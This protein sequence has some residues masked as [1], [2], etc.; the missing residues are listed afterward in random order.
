MK[1]TL[2][3]IP[4]LL[5]S[6]AC[7]AQ[8]CTGSPPINCSNEKVITPAIQPPAGL[9]VVSATC[10][11]LVIKWTGAANQEH[12]AHAIHHNPLTNA[13]DSIVVSNITCDANNNWTA[14]IPVVAN[15]KY[16]L[17]VEA[18]G[19]INGCAF[20][21]YST[22]RMLDHAVAACNQK[23]NML[24]FSGKVMLQGAYNLSTGK[25]NNTLNETGLLQAH[26]A[27]QPYASAGFN[28]AGTENVGAAFFAAHPTIVDWVLLEIRDP[29]APLSIVGRRAVFVTQDGTLVD[30][31]GISTAIAFSGIAPGKYNVSLRHRN[32]LAI[33]S[34]AAVDFLNGTGSYDFTTANYNTYKNQNY[35]STTQ[36]GNVWAM[37]GGNVLHSGVIRYS[38][39]GNIPSYILSVTLGGLLST[40]INNVY[41]TE[42]INMNGNIRYTGPGNDQ[43][44]LLNTVLG[45]SMNTILKEQL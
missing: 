4:L 11:T 15:T 5:F 17:T 20:Y 14:T 41:A 35:T 43:S 27:N 19:M 28:Y 32:H 36:M 37:R 12:L 2:I 33:R 8:S 42:D 38:G 34:S 21:S 10:S 25:M 23:G 24:T 18:K 16:S 29:N 30:T 6:S 39:P 3:I 9:Q 26:A 31:D 7:I 44:A 40:I 45:G 13:M 1:Y 22:V